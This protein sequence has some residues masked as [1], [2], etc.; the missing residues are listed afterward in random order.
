MSQPVTPKSS[1]VKLTLCCAV[2]GL[3]WVAPKP[4][5]AMDLTCARCSDNVIDCRSG[6]CVPYRCPEPSLWE[7]FVRWVQC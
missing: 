7:R 6:V 4:A 2:L 3:L 5:A 1:L